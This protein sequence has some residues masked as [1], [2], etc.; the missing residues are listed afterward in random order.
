MLYATAIYTGMRKGE[1]AAL[2]WSQIDLDRRLIFVD[3]SHSGPTKSGTK[4]HIPI[5]SPLLP[6][7][8]QWR[9]R[10]FNPLVFPNGAGN[11]YDEN[12]RIFTEVLHRVIEQGGFEPVVDSTGV[13]KRYLTFHGLRHTFASHFMMNGGDL[14]KLQ[15]IGGWKSTEMVMRYSH[16]SPSA[17]EDVYEL[18]GSEKDASIQLGKTLV[19]DIMKG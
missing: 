16:L 12:G 7:L 14:F 8:R 5:M 17:F 9:L 13:T 19:T 4:R 10:G 1:L 2:T 18:F 3:R 15:K 11:Q 6:V